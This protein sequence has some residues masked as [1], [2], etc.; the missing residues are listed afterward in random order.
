MNGLSREMPQTKV[1]SRAG[2]SLNRPISQ[3]VIEE[4]IKNLPTK[5]SPGSSGFSAELYHTF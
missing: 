2:K 1:K 3:K 4:V 5:T